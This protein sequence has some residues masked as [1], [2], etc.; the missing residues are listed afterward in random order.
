MDEDDPV[1]IEIETA[2]DLK[3]P[4]VP[5]L[6]DKAVM[7]TA[8]Q[9]P[10]NLKEFAYRNAA[11]ID[12]GRDFHP[13]VDRLI[14]GIDLLLKGAASSPDPF[15]AGA[16]AVR[17]A[18]SPATPAGVAAA[19][20]PEHARGR[21]GLW[22]AAAAAVLVVLILGGGFLSGYAQLALDRILKGGA[23]DTAAAE[24]NDIKSLLPLTQSGFASIRGASTGTNEWET[25]RTIAGYSSCEIL[26]LNADTFSCQTDP[27]TAAAADK[28]LETKVTFLK[29]CLGSGWSLMPK[30][31]DSQAYSNLATRQIVGAMIFKSLGDDRTL[32]LSIYQNKTE[33]EPPPKPA[34]PADVPQN[35]CSELK[36]VVADGKLQFTSIRSRKRGDAWWA[37]R[38][39]LPGWDECDISQ[40]DSDNNRKLTYYSCKVS[41]FSDMEGVNKAVA[42]VAAEAKTCIGTGWSQRRGT[43]LDNAD[44]IVFEAGNEDPTIEVRGRMFSRVWQLVLDVNAPEQP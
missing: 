36:D 18:Q 3:I 2:L 10:D 26:R 25:S 19:S 1:R 27:L 24:C 20:S 43:T 39:Q 6:V 14:R 23:V 32:S 5:V 11:E 7:P 9:L 42:R 29:T 17:G 30:F 40:I 12:S 4:I 15:A 21:R 41:P 44:R 38:V 31:G 13:H 35:F 34:K 28:L 8:A 16:H 22:Y 37:T 33:P